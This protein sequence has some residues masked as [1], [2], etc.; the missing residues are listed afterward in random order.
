MTSQKA[1]E[2]VERILPPGTLT[3]VKTLVF[4]HSWNSKEYG[5]IAKEVRL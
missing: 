4:H 5:A 1:L 3:P 2:I